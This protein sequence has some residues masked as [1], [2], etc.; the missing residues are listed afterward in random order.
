MLL[1]LAAG[2]AGYF[3]FNRDTTSTAGPDPAPTTPD[4]NLV[5]LQSFAAD[6]SLAGCSAIPP[7]DKQLLRRSCTEDGV[8]ATYSLFKPGEREKERAYVARLHDR[9]C[10]NCERSNALSPDGRRG[11]Y[12]E[13]V[14]QAAENQKWYAAAWWDDGITNPQGAGV[15]TMRKEWDQN[16]DDPAGELREI[17]LGW[18]YELDE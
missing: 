2:G 18:G 6:R 14:Y 5:A 7:N 11:E 17:W 13:Y 12:I 10:E 4:A 9:D 3:W 15:M 1:L 16:P 8:V